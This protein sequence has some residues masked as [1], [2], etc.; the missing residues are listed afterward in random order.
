MSSNALIM[1]WRDC[2]SW[3][4]VHCDDAIGSV[5]SLLLRGNYKVYMEYDLEEDYYLVGEKLNA[6]LA[7]LSHLKHMDLSENN[8]QGSRIPDFIG[9]FKQ[10]S[11]LNLSHTGFSG[12]IPH[13]IGNLSNLKALNLYSAFFFLEAN[14]MSWVLG[15]SSLEHLDFREVGLLQAKNLDMVLYMIPTLKY[16]SLKECRLSN[17]DL[18]LGLHLNSSILLPNI[19]HLDLSSNNFEG[20]LPHFFSE[21]NILK[22]P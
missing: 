8:F 21:P 20:Q 18:G 9:S 6:H 16:L 7:E 1:G 4:G 17:V 5:V 15:L 19:E 13:H 11:Y 12:I 10:L 14:D 22:V 2:C 3:K